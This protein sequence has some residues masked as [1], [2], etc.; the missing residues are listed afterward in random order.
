MRA[1]DPRERLIGDE[2]E[3]LRTD[4]VSDAGILN[5]IAAAM[6]RVSAATPVQPDE[7]PKATQDQ[8]AQPTEPEITAAFNNWSGDGRAWCDPATFRAGYL[9]R[10][11]AAT[12][13]Q[14]AQPVAWYMPLL[15]RYTHIEWGAARPDAGSVAEWHPLYA[16]PS[17]QPSREPTTK[18][19]YAGNGVSMNM[20]SFAYMR[21]VW[22]AM[23]DASQAQPS[24]SP[25]SEP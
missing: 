9:A 10:R 16:A 14:T 17:A 23:Y 25:K 6:W 15:G 12:I 5:A 20:E 13:Q 11:A 8:T 24:A 2:V 21:A 3:R 1:I 4:Y 7:Q 19:L 18:M 22:Q